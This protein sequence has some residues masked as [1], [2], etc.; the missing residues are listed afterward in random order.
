MKHWA[1]AW[2]ALRH[3][4]YRLYFAGQAVSIL[5]NWMQQVALGWLVYRL[6]GSAMLLGAVAFLSQIPQL[7]V[8][9]LAGFALVAFSLTAEVWLAVVMLF[10][11]GFGLINGNASSST[12]LQ[13]ILPERLRGRV[14]A[15]YSAA[16]LGA[17]ALGGL[18]SGA[19]AD[20]LGPGETLL[21]LGV[22]LIGAALFF[23]IRLELFRM[24]LRPIYAR[25]GIKRPSMEEHS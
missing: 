4:S 19:L 1:H 24:H 21:W 14:L 9:P 18:I 25:L 20:H 5:G 6:T 10:M 22:V 15:I 13:T 11:L 17:A 7:V 3:A 12:I 8:A 23:R 2:R 16:N